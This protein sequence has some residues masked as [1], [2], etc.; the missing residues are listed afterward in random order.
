[1][2]FG[3]VLYC[4]SSA[5]DGDKLEMYF[6]RGRVTSCLAGR[7]VLD[8]DSKAIV[9]LLKASGK[10]RGVLLDDELFRHCIERTGARAIAVCPC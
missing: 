7:D 10:V 3:G 2:A 1:M 8:V 4:F 6:A 5:Q 9:R